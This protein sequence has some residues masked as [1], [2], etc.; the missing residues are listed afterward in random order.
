MYRYLLTATPGS[1][2]VTQNTA[3]AV[4]REFT[5]VGRHLAIDAAAASATKHEPRPQ[6]AHPRSS[7]HAPKH[8]RKPHVDR[9]PQRI[10]R[11]VARSALGALARADGSSEPKSTQR[12]RRHKWKLTNGEMS[13]SAHPRPGR[14]RCVARRRH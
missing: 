11:A 1:D 14:W 13:W 3:D 5:A 2:P 6:T 9:S 8:S 7:P 12:L 4:G 10:L